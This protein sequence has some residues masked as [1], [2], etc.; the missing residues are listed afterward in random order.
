MLQKSH[1]SE[2]LRAPPVSPH[3]YCGGREHEE[4]EASE[5][6]GPSSKVKRPSAFSS[7]PPLA[8]PH[9]AQCRPRLGDPEERQGKWE[10]LEGLTDDR[11]GVAG[12][13]HEWER[14]MV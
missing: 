4:I 5:E 7:L 10:R 12:P 13:W 9:R 11:T 6:R 1:G 14:N 2:D 8:L 3:P